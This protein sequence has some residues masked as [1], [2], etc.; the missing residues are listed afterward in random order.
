MGR[1]LAIPISVAIALGIGIATLRGGKPVSFAFFEFAPA[2]GAGMGAACACTNPTGAKGETLTFSRSTSG[3]CMK[4]PV[5]SGIASGD[6]VTCTSGQPRVMR[7]GDGTQPLGLLVEPPRT[8]RIIQS[9]AFDN[10]AWAV[11][12]SGATTPV[13]T[14]NFAAGPSNATTAERVQFGACPTLGAVSFI[15]QTDLG[16]SGANAGSVYCRGT[17]ASQTINFCVFDDGANEGVCTQVTCPS[18]SWSRFEKTESVSSTTGG[19]VIGCNNGGNYIG[20]AN[21]GAADVLLAGAQ[22]EAGTYATSYIATTTAAVTRSQDFAVFN[23]VASANTTVSFA[24]SVVLD[25]AIANWGFDQDHAFMDLGTAGP[26][27]SLLMDARAVTSQ[28]TFYNPSAITTAIGYTMAGQ[29]TV[30]RASAT[31]DGGTCT[32]TDPSPST[33]TNACS[34]LAATTLVELGA[35]SAGSATGLGGVISQVC[36]DPNPTRCH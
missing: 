4:G 17:S 10:A 22:Y 9:D 5:A 24:A 26:T 33:G 1:R 12:G 36:V 3:A 13:V 11:V 2:N 27:Y 19:L 29:P 35:Y 31:F 8:N 7:G 30:N 25:T 20:N 6:L 18:T 34:T 16:S 23:S 15:L 14:A 21:T 32:V 28:F